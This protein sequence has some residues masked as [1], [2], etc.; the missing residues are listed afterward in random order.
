MISDLNSV[1][2]PIVR[3][4]WRDAISK[5]VR[6]ITAAPAPAPQPMPIP[7]RSGPVP[8]YMRRAVEKARGL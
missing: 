2:L 1:R 3:D 6:K 5:A 7:L 4:G 8:D